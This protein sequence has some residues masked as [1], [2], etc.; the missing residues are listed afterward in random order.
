MFPHDIRRGTKSE[1]LVETRFLKDWFEF[2][3]R[4]VPDTQTYV[5]NHLR[6]YFFFH[7]M[8]LLKVLL[9]CG[10]G[11][12][13]LTEVLLS[14]LVAL[15]PPQRPSLMESFRVLFSVQSHFHFIRSPLDL[16]LENTAPRS[17]VTQ[18]PLKL[19]SLFSY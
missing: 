6:K 9:C 11:P 4:S 17:T 2:A 18:K 7:N 10:S 5:H 8:P 19:P 12:I 13:C 15:F 16:F 3:G 14:A 1:Q